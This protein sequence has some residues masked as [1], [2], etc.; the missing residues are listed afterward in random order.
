M[1]SLHVLPVEPRVGDIVL[2]NTHGVPD[3]VFD[4]EKAAAVSVFKEGGDSTQKVAEQLADLARVNAKLTEGDSPFAASARE[5]G[6][7]LAQ[8]Q[9]AA[10]A[11]SSRQFGQM[12]RMFRLQIRRDVK[13]L[14]NAM[15][16]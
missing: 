14:I 5:G 13:K 3:N 12:F 16:D 7:P 1:W 8:V 9:E 6:K 4:L 11:H 10:V 15:N 2:F